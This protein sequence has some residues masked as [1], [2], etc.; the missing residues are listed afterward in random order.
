MNLLK[1]LLNENGLLDGVLPDDDGL[2][3]TVQS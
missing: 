3:D 1:N 2:P